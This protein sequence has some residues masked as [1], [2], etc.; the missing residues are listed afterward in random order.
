M[1]LSVCGAGAKTSDLRMVKAFLPSDHQPDLE[2]QGHA[3]MRTGC[4]Y[5]IPLLPTLLGPAQGSPCRPLLP[6]STPIF[7]KGSDFQLGSGSLKGIHFPRLCNT[8]TGT[9]NTPL[10]ELVH[11]EESTKLSTYSLSPDDVSA[12]RGEGVERE[13]GC[14]KKLT[15]IPAD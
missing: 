7:L 11:I 2:L 13:R 9:T 14:G 5:M 8:Q 10:Q 12:R 15:L 3:L 4:P 6:H 1:N